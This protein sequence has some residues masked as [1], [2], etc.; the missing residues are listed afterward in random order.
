MSHAAKIAEL[1]R[2][3]AARGHRLFTGAELDELRLHG[4][5]RALQRC[6]VN[7]FVTRPEDFVRE[8]RTVMALRRLRGRYQRNQRPKSCIK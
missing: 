7:E 8:A 3:C 2:A 4:I 6:S 5:C 1:Q